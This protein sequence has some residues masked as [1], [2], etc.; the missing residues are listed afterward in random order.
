MTDWGIIW[1][2]YRQSR[3]F[4]WKVLFETSLGFKALVLWLTLHCFFLLRGLGCLRF[5]PGT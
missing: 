5:G 4:G 3:N 1:Y 2:C